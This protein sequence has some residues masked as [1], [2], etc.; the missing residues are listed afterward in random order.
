MIV[1]MMVMMHIMCM[2]IMMLKNQDENAYCGPDLVEHRTPA[3]VLVCPV[4][5]S[6][7]GVAVDVHYNVGPPAIGHHTGISPF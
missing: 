7:I 1:L 4:G 6:L 3:R 5:T 2:V